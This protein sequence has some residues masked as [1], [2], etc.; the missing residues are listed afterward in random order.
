MKAKRQWFVFIFAVASA[1][2]LNTQCLIPKAYAAEPQEKTV[3]VTFTSYDGNAQVENARETRTIYNGVSEMIPV[4]PLS[5]YPGGWEARGWVASETATSGCIDPRLVTSLWISDD[6]TYYG[7]YERQVELAFETGDVNVQV[8]A[9]ASCPQFVNSSDVT[10]MYGGQTFLLPPGVG[11]GGALFDG[12]ALHRVDGAKY[13]AESWAFIDLQGAGG[14]PMHAVWKNVYTIHYERLLGRPETIPADQEKIEGEPIPLT[15]CD[16][17]RDGM[18]FTGWGRYSNTTEAAYQPKEDFNEDSWL[19]PDGKITLYAVW[20]YGITFHLEGGAFAEGVSNF[21]TFEHKGTPTVMRG[22]EPTKTGYNFRGWVENSET[23][24]PQYYRDEPIGTAPLWRS[25]NLYAVW[26][27]IGPPSDFD[28][29]LCIG[30]S[31]MAGCNAL[32]AQQDRDLTPDPNIFLFNGT[33]W[34]LAQFDGNQGLNRYNNVGSLRAQSNLNPAFYFAWHMQEQYPGR[35]IGIV[36][37]AMAGASIAQWSKGNPAGYFGKAVEMTQAARAQGG[38]LRGILWL[39]GETDL[40]DGGDSLANYIITLNQLVDDLRAELDV[41]AQD[42]PFIAG[43]IP[44][45]YNYGLP[46]RPDRPAGS[47]ST[48]E[49]NSLLQQFVKPARNTD[50]ISAALNPEQ[51]QENPAV[52]GLPAQA[53]DPNHFS[54]ASQREMGRRYALKMLQMQ[55]A[56]PVTYTITYRLNNGVNNSGLPDEQIKTAGIPVSLNDKPTRS[57]MF[58]K[59][60]G[61]K[62]DTRVPEYHANESFNDDYRFNAEGNLDLWAVWHYTITFDPDGGAFGADFEDEMDGVNGGG[63]FFITTPHKNNSYATTL[64]MAQPTLLGQNPVGWSETRGATTAQYPF[65]ATLAGTA[66]NRNITLYPVWEPVSEPP[67]EGLMSVAG[68]KPLN[69]FASDEVFAFDINIQN[70]AATAAYVNWKIKGY[71][72]DEPEKSGTAIIPAG[73][74]KVTVRPPGHMDTGHYVAEAWVPGAEGEERVSD[75]FAVVVPYE[76][77]PQYSNPSFESPFATDTALMWYD[78]PKFDLGQRTPEMT[79]FIN[80]YARAIRLSGVTW[81][82][83]RM[84]W[85]VGASLSGGS[86]GYDIYIR[87]IEAYANIKRLMCFIGTPQSAIGQDNRDMGNKLPDDLRAIYDFAVDYGQYYGN[88]V[89]MW[90]IWN[91]QENELGPGEGADKYAAFLKAASIGF[92]DAGVPVTMGGML[93]HKTNAAWTLYHDTMFENGITGYVEAYNFHTHQNNADPD[94][95]TEETRA[96]PTFNG[97]VFPEE[98]NRDHI[99]LKNSLPGGAALP[100]WVT[101]AGGG[102]ANSPDGLD[103]YSKQR[104][105]ARY[106]VTSAA[107]S[108]STGVDK[109]FWF[110]GHETE[111]AEYQDPYENIYWG[112]FSSYNTLT[113]QMTP[114]AAYAAQAAMTE[115]MGEA[116]YLGEVNLSADA[117]TAGA[118]GY[119]FRD[120][121]DTVLILW[122]TDNVNVPLNLQKPNGTKTDMMGKKEALPSINN[123]FELQLGPDPIY[124]RVTG[125]I[126]AGEYTAAEHE[127]VG[128]DLKPLMPAQRIVLDQTFRAES[129]DRSRAQGYF[130][131]PNAETPVEVTIYNFNDFEINGIV[132]GSFGDAAGYDVSGPQNVTIAANSQIT[133]NFT[134]TAGDYDSGNPAA[135]LT[136]TGNFNDGIGQTTPSVTKVENALLGI[137]LPEQPDYVG[138][139]LSKWNLY[140]NSADPAE[141]HNWSW[142]DGKLVHEA[143]TPVEV[144]AH[145]KDATLSNGIVSAKLTIEPQPGKY[146]YWSGLAVRQ[147]PNGGMWSSG[148]LIFL[149]S[150]SVQV[151]KCGS[152]H[153]GPPM[154]AGV[155]MGDEVELTVRM[156]D[157]T[158][159]VFVNG[160]FIR[161]FNDDTWKSGCVGIVGHNAKISCKDF[162]VYNGTMNPEILPLPDMSGQPDYCGNLNNWT[163]FLSQNWQIDIDNGK[164]VHNAPGG[165][166]T[167]HARLK[168][169]EDMTNGCVSA[170]FSMDPK[171]ENTD[172]WAGLYVRRTKTVWEDN[173]W[174][175]NSYMF[176]LKPDGKLVIDKSNAGR[177]PIAVA[178]TNVNMYDTANYVGEVEL[179]VVMEGNRFDVYVD[180]NWVYGFNDN[181]IGRTEAEPVPFYPS[182]YVGPVANNAHVAFSEFRVLQ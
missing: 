41:T 168:G 10:R 152:G 54:S 6:I 20:H 176:Y 174:W 76:Q 8:P 143:S 133:K 37:D 64:P 139:S 117:I 3:T 95:E 53:G 59:G 30:Q 181:D 39:Q 85:N 132:S 71:F 74:T 155:T 167:I 164:L 169:T 160:K 51:I 9:N 124:L 101:E 94:Q 21:W 119:V 157:D 131:R 93:R 112:F 16:P 38:T 111:P 46:G 61:L 123:V 68:T 138:D 109:H 42:C 5:E 150:G 158:I 65:G 125:E 86:R 154:A 165:S 57:N 24:V 78:K 153:M 79:A 136:F 113:K 67:A 96:K 45:S 161:G 13:P 163:Q 62:Q 70:A 88:E 115:A 66:F 182:G 26:E 144:Y 89:G 108:L 69:I 137:D 178:Q 72:E 114:Y 120:G 84:T 36:S 1:L 134:V 2:F 151:W 91:E 105:Q 15:A 56:G 55:A 98:R 28:V 175:E 159:E 106:L 77:R 31:N 148:Y 147:N 87:D 35:T 17:Q 44:Y 100:A 162:R 12:W 130:I 146:G 14:A 25:L 29:Y 7:V 102:I 116:V 156:Q 60:W 142:A 177:I 19:G 49:F 110:Y 75:N 99:D 166:D 48:Y 145:L 52:A 18:V 63:L 173:L 122:A 73:Q 121:S 33:A 81:T 149:Q 104:A 34:E 103:V 172:Y 180:R 90:E 4:P 50:Y 47:F 92:H 11:K 97:N 22:D 129:R 27:E 179:A 140:P 40:S 58:F 128:I 107:T 32:P 171:F 83:E 170:R 23:T 80:D 126:P 118:K 135:K 141:N 43:E 82:R 127:R